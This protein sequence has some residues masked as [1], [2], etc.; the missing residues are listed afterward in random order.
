MEL[1]DKIRAYDPN[2]DEDAL[3]RAYVYAMQKHG[4]NPRASGDPYFSHPVEVAYKLTQYCLTLPPSSPRCCTIRWRTIDATLDEIESLFGSEIRGL[5]DGVTKLNRLEIKSE[6]SKQAE[7]FRKLVL[8]MANDLRVLMVKR[9]TA[10]NMET[11]HYIPKPENA[12]ASPA[13]RLK[14][15]QYWPSASV[16]AA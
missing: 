8:A 14:F 2:A 7:N 5:V 6:S 11:L 10:H 1:V 4:S 12:S 9:P 13:K 16:C 15:M 3:N